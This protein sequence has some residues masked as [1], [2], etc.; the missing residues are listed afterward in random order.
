MDDV[1]LTRTGTDLTRPGTG[2]DSESS[3]SWLGEQH[4]KRKGG[5]SSG[6]K[7]LESAAQLGE[8]V[9]GK[10]ASGT[11]AEKRDS[12]ELGTSGRSQTLG[13]RLDATEV[14]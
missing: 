14:R 12:V 3:R 4:S 9:S 5:R 1:G 6:K 7:I 8:S 11:V 13:R 2:T 10:A